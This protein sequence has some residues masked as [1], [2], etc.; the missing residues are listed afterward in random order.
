MAFEKIKEDW[1]AL[2][3]KF[4]YAMVAIAVLGVVVVGVQAVRNSSA[5]A[6]KPAASARGSAPAAQ[7]AGP[8]GTPVSFRVLPTN[9]RNQGLEDL[10]LK[11]EQM[12]EQVSKLSA[13]QG[14]TPPSG[15]QTI[16]PAQSVQ[17]ARP[18]GGASAETLPPPVDFGPASKGAV[19][20]GGPGPAFVPPPTDSPPEP[21][22][23][24]KPRM[25]EWNAEQTPVKEETASNAVAGPAIPVN[26]AL[27]GV[28][29]SGVN[30]RQAGSIAG[31]VGSVTSANSVGA[32]F[33]TKI[34]GS[35]I[36]PNGWKLSDLGDCLLGGSA[37]AVLSTGRA[38]AIA[39][40]IS[41]IGADGELWESP[42]KA[43][44]LDVDGTLGLA[45][46]V[47]SKQGSLLLQAAL[48]GVASGLGTALSPTQL[49]SYNSNATSGSTQGYQLPN[50]S[51][52]A[53]SAVGTG[54]NSATSQLSKFY[55]EYA[56]E[57]FPV[58]EVV[59]GTRITWVLK[60]TVELKKRKVSQ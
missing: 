44:G 10:H 9:N 57:V 40:N 20:P 53:G 14:A 43:Y 19:T 28:M 59:S 23:P 27:E 8:P 38:Y 50:P 16:G 48:T 15:G 25:R 29:L 36:L 2:D 17:A 13:A 35:A 33:V 52:V 31:A 5:D 49:A 21:V 6:R 7:V 24:A 41:C 12:A 32:P 58:V 11:I 1:E 51:Y 4:R 22:V 39:D 30:A 3:P 46:K 37:V 45:G 56:R 42:I 18:G 47:V 60:E 54:V 26:S 55:L 34:K